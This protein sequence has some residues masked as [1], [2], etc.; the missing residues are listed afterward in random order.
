MD[1]DTQLIAYGRK[2]KAT[3]SSRKGNMEILIFA[4]IATRN[5]Y[6]QHETFVPEPPKLQPFDLRRLRHSYS[7]EDSSPR[8]PSVRQKWVMV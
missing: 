8:R 2:S 6:T 7:A 3:L 4:L 1:K 5:G